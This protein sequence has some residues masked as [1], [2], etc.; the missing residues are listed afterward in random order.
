MAA[1]PGAVDFEYTFSGV[2]TWGEVISSLCNDGWCRTQLPREFYT[3]SVPLG[4]YEN[5]FDDAFKALSF[6]ALADGYLLKKTGRKKPFLVTAVLD[7]ATRSS[8]IS[9]LDTNVRQVDSK[10]LFRYRY[11]DSLKCLSRARMMDSLASIVDTVHYPS[12]RYR[13]SFYVVTSAFLRTLGI[14]WTTLWAKGTLASRPDLISDWALRAV[15]QDDT[16]AEFRSIEVD[17]DSSTVLH[18]GSQKKE[19]KA[20]IVYSNGVAQNDY[21]WRDYGLTLTLSRDM[22]QGVRADYQLAQRDENNSILKGKF[23]GGG[24][25][26]ISAW[27]V[28]DSF[29]N[30]F[31]GIPWLYKIPV[32]GYLFG[33]EHRDKVKSFFVIEVLPVV[34]DSVSFPVLD[35]L[36]LED[37]KAYEGIEDSTANSQPDSVHREEN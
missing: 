18:W 36:R 9:C 10:D 8:Y 27:G 15:A 16:T 30:S 6:Q 3:M 25:D 21:E 20:T 26:S 35:S 4:I 5:S 24:K 29:Q 19:E 33:S 34:R 37:V 23:G 17:L 31:V 7:E 11:A 13:V 2:Y 14:D 1:A 32:L 12:K 28:Y 22:V